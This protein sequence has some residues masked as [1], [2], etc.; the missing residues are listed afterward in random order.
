MHRR[1]SYTTGLFLLSAALLGGCAVGPR[2]SPPVTDTPANWAVSGAPRS[3]LAT[4]SGFTSARIDDAWWESF[5]DPELTSLIARAVAS[6][7]DARQAVLRIE[8][9]REQVRLAGAPG[10]PML[11]ASASYTNERI[12]E[13]TATT[14]ILGAAGSGAP[15]GVASALPGLKNPFDAYQY[16]LGGSWEIDLFGRVRRSVEAAGA[17]AGA[18]IEDSRA[19]RVSLA[20][21][22]AS[23]YID[24]RGVEARRAV[25][26]QAIA[27]AESLRK[28]AI[29]ARRGDL[30]DDLEVAAASA[31][32]ANA[33]AQLPPLDQASAADRN[34]LALLLAVRPGALDAELARP[35]ALPPTPPVVPVGLPSDLARRRPDIRGAEALLHAAV[36][37]QGVAVAMLYPSFSLGGSAGYE[38][39]RPAALSEWAA[40]YLNFGPTLDLPLFDGG[41]RR[42]NVRLADIHAREAALAYA[43][44]VLVALHET[45]DA[46]EAYRQEQFRRTSLEAALAQ[47][48]AALTLAEAR[49]QTGTVS[50]HDV[51]AARDKLQQA[52]LGVVASRAAASQDLVGLYRALGGGWEGAEAQ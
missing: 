37:R 9:A 26:E 52:Q 24:L 34:R 47:S 35:A 20:A 5:G 2:Y 48:Q 29:D 44:T 10:R 21:E 12:S 39:S 43:Q 36:A 49:Y 17:E 14:S 41:Q 3:E 22:V 18:A 7:F 6:S 42:G 33:R 1:Q 27:T 13:R 46:M 23:T 11:N 15:G 32:V 4:A 16:G 38:A 40:H 45:E 31:A 30:G 28:L 25:V 50:F 8:E 51:L 19:V